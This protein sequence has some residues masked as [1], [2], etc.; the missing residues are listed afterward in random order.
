M[1]LTKLGGQRERAL[2]LAAEEV[3]LARKWGAP[4][5]LG[6]ALWTQ[7]VVLSGTAGEESLREAVA[8]LEGSPARL[9]YARALAELGA[10]LHRSGSRREARPPL[11]QA[12]ELARACGATPLA[13]RVH[14]ELRA[15]GA[16]VPKLTRTG[17]DT[18]TASE[19]RVARFAAAGM[20]NKQIAQ[21]LFVTLKTVEAHLAHAYR[22]L[23]I[24]SRSELVAVLGD[25]SDAPNGAAPDGASLRV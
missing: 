18:L 25:V 9:E 10:S 8:V 24:S 15:S 11:R 5:A 20:T 4:R 2:E 13:E 14:E 3:E 7:G 1:A 21:E 23:H 19:R 6:H 22:K 17:A 12:L 16:S